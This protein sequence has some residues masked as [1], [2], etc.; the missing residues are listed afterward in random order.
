MLD[1]PDR[2]VLDKDRL[3][4]ACLRLPVV[5]DATRL[6][7][8]IDALG[9]EVWGTTDGRVGVHSRAE[10]VFLRGYAPAQGEL[11]IEDRP[12]LDRLPYAREVLGLLA[13]PPLR[14]LLARLPA[15]AAIAPHIDRAPYFAKTLRI[16]VPVTTS[17]RVFMWCAGLTY[18]MRAG[19]VWALNNSTHHGVWNADP[20]LSRTHL[21]CDFLPAP[22]LL[23]LLARGDRRL[24]NDDPE[25]RRHLDGLRP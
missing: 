4:G 18:R 5:V 12:I 3:V 8:E 24:G 6:G 17:E 21:I 9:T 13:A 22:A 2:P 23:D 16:H 19:E 15:G 1:L 10:A 25:V 7:T 20:G 11:P 14:C